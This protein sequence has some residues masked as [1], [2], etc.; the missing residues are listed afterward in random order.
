[1][2]RKKINFKCFD[3]FY[4]KIQLKFSAKLKAM[5]DILSSPNL[6]PF[7][8][9]FIRYYSYIR[10]QLAQE[11]VYF[12]YLFTIHIESRKFYNDKSIMWLV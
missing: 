5:F 7:K 11:N 9:F 6:S 1:M 3:K 12:F 4:N 2:K 8:T 10:T